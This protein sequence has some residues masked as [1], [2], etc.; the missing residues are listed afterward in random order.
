LVTIASIL[1]NWPVIH[2]HVTIM[3]HVETVV[4]Q[5]ANFSVI[6]HIVMKEILAI[7]Q[8]S[9]L[10]IVENICL[11]I[12]AKMAENVPFTRIGPMI[13]NTL[14]SATVKMD[15]LASFVRKKTHACMALGVM[16]TASANAILVGKVMIV[17]K[18]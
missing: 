17:E 4:I 11:I 14:Q 2:I 8:K 13:V 9:F 15:G 5:V 18:Q 16:R 6:V 7:H 10:R 12:H 1:E 3:V